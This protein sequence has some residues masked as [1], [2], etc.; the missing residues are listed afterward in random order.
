MNYSDQTGLDRVD[1]R[2]RAGRNIELREDPADVV[3]DGFLGELQLRADLFVRQT[4]RDEAQNIGFAGG[5]IADRRARIGFVAAFEHAAG[6]S[7]VDIRRAAGEDTEGDIEF[8]RRD[9]LDDE[10]VGA[11]GDAALHDVGVGV[12]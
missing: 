10:T 3:L 9:V 1:G 5:Q 7:R 8:A 2:L 6:D 12:G 11:G 4:A